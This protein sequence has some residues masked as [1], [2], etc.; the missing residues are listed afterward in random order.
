[1]KK[2][3]IIVGLMVI[4][5]LAVAATKHL[6]CTHHNSEN[7]IIITKAT[8]DDESDKAE[9]KSYGVGAPCL[10]TNSCTTEIYNKETLPT[11][12]RLTWFK[13]ITSDL[14]VS[15]II[16][17]NRENLSLVKRETFLG[18]EST[19]LGTCEVKVDETKKLL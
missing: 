5:S 12:I 16:D 1:M 4:P 10:N 7:K 17:V 19:Y 11:V 6:E 2:S 18:K 14:S 3:I 13:R 8:I 15:A 9:V